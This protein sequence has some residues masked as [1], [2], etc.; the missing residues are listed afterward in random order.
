MARSQPTT[1]SK[2]TAR[3]CMTNG[4]VMPKGIDQRSVWVRRFKDIVALHTSDRGGVERMSQAEQSLVR[5]I[6]TLTVE[7][8]QME[9]RFAESE[10]GASANDLE[11]Y[12]RASNTLRRHCQTLGLKRRAKDV[13]PDLQSYLRNRSHHV[14]VEHGS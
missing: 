2:R 10:T 9:V 8:E 3:S 7:L 11:R 4:R 6:A 5:C 13:T 12:Q 1:L 14:T